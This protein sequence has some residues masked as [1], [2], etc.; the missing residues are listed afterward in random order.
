M[1][2]IH[3]LLLLPLALTSSAY[4]SA[5]SWQ[6]SPK[7]SSLTF[8]ATQNGAPV[9]GTFSDFTGEIHFDPKQLKDSDIKIVVNLNAISGPYDELSDTLK[10]ADW[11]NVA[12]YPKAIYQSKEITQTGDKTYQAKGTLTLRDKTLPVVIQFKQAVY[13]ATMATMEG[14]TIIKRTQFGVGQGE[15]ADTKTVADEVQLKFTVMAV[16]K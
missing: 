15:W 5:P 8:I 16:R 12:A 13:S 9:N 2:F 1:R 10:S 14:T 3:K 7:A 4:A 11:F 6:I